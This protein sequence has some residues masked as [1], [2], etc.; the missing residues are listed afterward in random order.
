MNEF[1]TKICSSLNFNR[2]LKLQSKIILLFSK[3]IITSIIYL[4]LSLDVTWNIL[5]FQLPSYMKTERLL[6][7]LFVLKLI[8][9][10]K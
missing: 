8:K 9:S 4:N 5:S 3:V 10:D 1:K 7:E 2:P 6:R